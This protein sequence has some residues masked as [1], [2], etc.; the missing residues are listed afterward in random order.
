MN[1]KDWKVKATDSD[2]VQ[3]NISETADIKDTMLTLFDENRIPLVKM[4]VE[5]REIYLCCHVER[6]MFIQ[7]GDS[8]QYVDGSGYA[9][10]S[11]K[12]YKGEFDN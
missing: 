5:S 12:K 4:K 1:L 8:V 3:V 7:V 10:F 9:A 2:C 6:P 11:E